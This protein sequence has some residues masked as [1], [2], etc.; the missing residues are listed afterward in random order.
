MK[1]ITIT[2][3]IGIFFLTACRGTAPLS[4]TVPVTVSDIFTSTPSPTATATQTPLPFSIPTSSITPLPTIPTFTPTFDARTIVTVTPATKAECPKEDPSVIAKFATPNNDGS[5]EIYSPSD[6]LDYLNTGG[7]P[8]QLRDSGLAEIVD[9][10]GDGVNEVVY[11]GFLGGSYDILGCKDGKY[12]DFLDFSGDSGVGQDV[13]DLNKNGVPEIILCDVVHYGFVDIS[14]FEWDGNKF[15]SLINMGKYSAT[16]D[17]VI[18]W[19]HATWMSDT[20]YKLIDTN[21]DGLK[22]FMV[23]YDVNQ[24]CGGFGDFCDGTP[25]RAQTTILAWNGQNYVM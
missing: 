22:E 19:V 17:T 5:Y 13:V 11:R 3:L 1:R 20:H 4:P 24:L 23:V 10:T 16:D 2:L 18:D 6:I 9:L 15:R 14:I 12:Q 8:A 25:A 21:G 7:T